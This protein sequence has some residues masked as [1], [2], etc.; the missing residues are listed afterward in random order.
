MLP[1][2]LRLHMRLFLAFLPS[3]YRGRATEILEKSEI[4]SVSWKEILLD[5][6]AITLLSWLS[7]S[8]SQVRLSLANALSA[9]WLTFIAHL[10]PTTSCI[11][12]IILALI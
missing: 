7:L 12:S 1:I 9:G 11:A 10:G 3:L 8:I 5:M 6:P 4:A 2:D